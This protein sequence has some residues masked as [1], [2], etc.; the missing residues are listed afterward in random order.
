MARAAEAAGVQVAT[1][2]TK[3]VERGKADGVYIN[4]S[5]VG[6][7]EHDLELG[8]GAIRAG[9]R[10]IVSGS[11]GDHGMAIMIAR[12]ELA[13]EVE[14]ESD[15]A[16]LNGLVA[17]LLRDLDLSDD[18]LLSLLDPRVAVSPVAPRGLR[19]RRS[20]GSTIDEASL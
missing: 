16:P 1:G 7:I 4:T 15:T 18:E 2:D 6:R 8:P 14:L 3:V 12:G 5:G 11:I 19:S 10:V 20:S 17:D 9:D 13:L